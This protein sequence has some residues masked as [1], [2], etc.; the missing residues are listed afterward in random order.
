MGFYEYDDELKDNGMSSLTKMKIWFVVTKT[1]FRFGVNISELS[2]RNS[3][4]VVIEAKNGFIELSKL[5]HQK[6]KCW[7]FGMN[8][9]VEALM[10]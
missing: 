8:V 4:S 2:P 5:L 3:Q 9:V 6:F 10:M 1:F 7:F